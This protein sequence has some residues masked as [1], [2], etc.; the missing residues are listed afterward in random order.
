MIFK[1]LLNPVNIQSGIGEILLIAPVSYFKGGGIKSPKPPFLFDGAEVVIFEDHE[2]LEGKKW[3]EIIFAPEK[4]KLEANAIGDKGFMKFD[5]SITGM[6][7]GS[8]SLQH[9]QIKNWLNVPL[10]A[11]VRDSN[12]PANMYYQI[13]SECVPAY[14]TAT[15]GTGTTAEG[16]K[17]YEVKISSTNGYVQIYAGAVTDV[18]FLVRDEGPDDDF[19]LDD[20]TDDKFIA[21]P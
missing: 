11:L 7:P 6:I 16:N 4:N 8:Y 20:E 9:E 21:E 3:V 10:I 18:L 12:C 14:M 15:F 13:G 17:G 2:F 19:I 1:N 5:Q